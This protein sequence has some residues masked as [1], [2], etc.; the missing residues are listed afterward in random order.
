MPAS[1]KANN[2]SKDEKLL[3]AAWGS[4]L[5]SADN[6]PGS[7]NYFACMTFLSRDSVFTRKS[8]DFGVVHEST[9]VFIHHASTD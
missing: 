7:K 5:E 2:D 4:F 8:R 3:K 6:L 9:Q 1:K